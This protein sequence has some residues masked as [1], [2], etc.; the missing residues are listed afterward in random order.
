MDDKADLEMHMLRCAHG[1]HGPFKTD[2]VLVIFGDHV[3]HGSHKPVTF[4]QH[5][6]WCID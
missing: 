2:Q 5:F 4:H 1:D 3:A 6:R